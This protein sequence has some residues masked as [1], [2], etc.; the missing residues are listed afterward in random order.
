M[1]VRIVC[2]GDGTGQLLIV[3]AKIIESQLLIIIVSAVFYFFFTFP[4][5]ESQRI[6]NRYEMKHSLM[7]WTSDSQ[8]VNEPSTSVIDLHSSPLKSPT[9]QP[10]H[11]AKKSTLEN[12]EKVADCFREHHRDVEKDDKDT[13][14]P[15]TCHFKFSNNSI[16]NNLRLFHT[17]KKHK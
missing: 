17:P 11:H 13:F 4:K 9:A 6:C 1:T 8:D 15:I 5:I 14:K 12:S 16:H 3:K 7:R 10:V 2:K